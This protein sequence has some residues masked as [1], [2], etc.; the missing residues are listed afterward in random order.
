MTV[1]RNPALDRL[2][3]GANCYACGATPDEPCVTRRTRRPTL[4]HSGRIDRAVRLW[5]DANRG[6][7]LRSE[8]P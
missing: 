1:G 3:L 7:R 4:P 5:Q 8:T 2:A 6:A